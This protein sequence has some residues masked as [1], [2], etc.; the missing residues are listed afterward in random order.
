MQ[1]R[2][3]RNAQ[4]KEKLV[5]KLAAMDQAA[6]DRREKITSLSD[7]IRNLHNRPKR[8][9]PYAQALLPH[10][11]RMIAQI[12]AEDIKP[13]LVALNASTNTQVQDR[14]KLVSESIGKAVAPIVSM[15]EDVVSRSVVLVEGLRGD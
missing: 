7:T 13:I 1:K 3:E 12:I 4:L 2:Q 10:I 5:A 15:A 9:Y 8:T 11:E 14:R 6:L